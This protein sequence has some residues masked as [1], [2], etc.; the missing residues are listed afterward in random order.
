[1]RV[2]LIACLGL[3]AVRAR[4]ATAQHFFNVGQEVDGKIAV[5]ILAT[6]ADLT[7]SYYPVGEHVLTLHRGTSDSLQLRTDDAGVLEFLVAPGTYRLT[8]DR[9]FEWHGRRYR[10]DIPL[11]VVRDMDP[12]TLTAQNALVSPPA[13][14]LAPTSVTGRQKYTSVGILLSLLVAG[15]GQLYDGNA[16]KGAGLVALD[17][18]SFALGV[19]D[20][21]SAHGCG[22]GT[23]AMVLVSLAATIYSIATVPGEV[24]RYNATHASRTSVRPILEQRQHSVGLGLAV[25]F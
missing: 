24:R 16:K 1:M 4:V 25:G 20:C 19:V 3:L 6:L 2:A 7:E 22:A 12:V 21:A 10:W 13:L 18:G 15:G 11:V 5:Q 8:S 14:V 17:L 9:A 23:S